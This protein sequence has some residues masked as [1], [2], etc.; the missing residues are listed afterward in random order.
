M[1][2]SKTLILIP[3]YNER[4]NA[5][6]LCMHI[7]G[8]QLGADILFLDDNSPDGTGEILD[9]LTRVYSNVNVMHRPR[10]LGIGTAHLDGIKWAY[11]HNYTTLITMDCDFTHLPM[12]LP[13]FIQYSQ[14]NAVVVGSRYLLEESLREWSLVRKT[15]TLV[16]HLLTR[17][18]LRM[19]YD[20]TGAYRAY[21]LDII[22]PEAFGLVRSRGY[23]F[24][25]ESL[26]IL[27]RNHFRIKEFPIVLPART[28][29]H[30]KM[31]VTDAFNSLSR[32]MK[33][34]L[35][36][37]LNPSRYKIPEPAAVRDDAS[38][39]DDIGAWDEYWNKSASPLSHLYSGIAQLYRKNVI[40]KNLNRIVAAHFPA[41]SRVL[42]AGC[43]SGQVDTDIPGGLAI[44]A[45]DISGAGLQIYRRVHD[46][47]CDVIRGSIF[48]IPLGDESVDGIYHLGLL[49]HFTEE[50]IHRGFL[51]F[52]RVLRPGAR[53]IVFW[54]PN[55]G[56]SVNV[57]KVAHFVLNT[58]L[59][60][61]V[62]LH[63][64]EI[65]LVKSKTHAIEMFEKADFKLVN[66]YFGSR[67]LFTQCMIVVEKEPSRAPHLLEVPESEPAG[68]TIPV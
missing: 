37:L 19:K 64:D 7:I 45:L 63:P 44:T 33:I 34:S 31:R 61:N 56:L 46:N 4:E 11:E 66:Y 12:Y 67:D 48:D 47:E 53:M 22:P 36:T 25:Y 3:T 18:L 32:L 43:G 50:E 10:K 13:E 52:S 21:R 40:K 39:A 60:R 6:K 27:H 1:V 65:T 8:Y 41:G 17:T 51:E 38:R 42:H 5:E 23:S 24:F 20:A 55:F 49:E 62:K 14:D 30:S 16:G 57:L 59:R 15:L 28:Y 68:V 29:G 58:L 35:K 2:Q 26:Y 54:P 9:R